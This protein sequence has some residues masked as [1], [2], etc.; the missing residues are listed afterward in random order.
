M[1]AI[2][3]L[4]SPS[5]T[6]CHLMGVN[7]FFQTVISTVIYNLLMI[8]LQKLS[9]EPDPNHYFKPYQ[10][11]ATSEIYVWNYF[12]VCWDR[13]WNSDKICILT[14]FCWFFF[15]F[16]QRVKIQS[17]QFCSDT[18]VGISNISVFV[19]SSADL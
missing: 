16:N 13:W 11:L 1:A 19:I 12:N 18:S 2:H 10:P 5:W 17:M 7:C 9:T 14:Y 15:F 3:F 8:V 6:S 4:L